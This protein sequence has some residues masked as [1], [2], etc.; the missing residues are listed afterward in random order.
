MS[1]GRPASPPS[2]QSPLSELKELHERTAAQIEALFNSRLEDHYGDLAYHYSCSGNSLKAL[3]YLQLA[4]QQAIEL[5]ATTEATNLLTAAVH[6]L[7]PTEA[8]ASRCRASPS[9][10]CECAAVF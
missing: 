8:C 10:R 1:D 2:R 6:V 3:E 9:F 7:N 5:F 4:A